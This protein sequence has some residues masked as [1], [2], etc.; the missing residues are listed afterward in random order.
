MTTETFINDFVSYS[1]NSPNFQD[2]PY[3]VVRVAVPMSGAENCV[4]LINVHVEVEKCESSRFWVL[5][6]LQNNL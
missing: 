4:W 5:L 2:H 3:Y 1:L 6:S